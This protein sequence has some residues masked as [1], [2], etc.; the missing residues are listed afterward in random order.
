M[1]ELYIHIIEGD[2]IKGS[3]CKSIREVV[4]K[5]LS[6]KKKGEV[7]IDVTFMIEKDGTLEVDAVERPNKALSIEDKHKP[8]VIEVAV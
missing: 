8:R 6:I 4:L 2:S 3:E 7:R 5:N 1:K